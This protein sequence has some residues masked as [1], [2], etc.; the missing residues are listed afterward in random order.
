MKWQAG[1][2]VSLNDNILRSRRILIKK[3]DDGKVVA[4]TKILK[5]NKDRNVCYISAD[6]LADKGSY[7]ITALIFGP[8]KLYEFEGNMS[9]SV[10]ANTVTVLLGR[11]KEKEDRGKKRYAISTKGIVTELCFGERQVKLNKPMALMTVNM[12]SKGILVRMDSGS[13]EKGDCFRMTI[14]FEG[15]TLTFFCTVVRIQN[16]DMLTEEYG[17]EIVGTQFELGDEN[18]I[19][20]VENNLANR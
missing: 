14:M 17:C 5:Y 18:I 3:T 10:I 11:H 4:D 13:L 15:R 9:G 12:S 7:R 2:A 19:D 1:E 8:D 6:S 16:D 20:N